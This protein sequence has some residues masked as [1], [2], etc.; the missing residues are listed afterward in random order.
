[1]VFSDTGNCTCGNNSP[2]VK[3]IEGRKLD[4]LYNAEGAKINAGNVSNL[5]KYLPNVVIHSQ[6]VQNKKDEVV[7]H[8]EVDKSE[9]QADKHDKMLLQEFEH[10]FGKNT[11]LIIKQVDEIPREKSGKFRMIKNNVIELL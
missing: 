7:L 3:S 9:Y 8:I 4:F 5:L 2:I 6:F 11:K 1:M 10:K